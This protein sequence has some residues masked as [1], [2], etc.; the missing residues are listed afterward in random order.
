MHEGVTL[1]ARPGGD[2]GLDGLFASAAL[3]A[4]DVAAALRLA[5]EV[6]AAS[7]G[8]GRGRTVQYLET[9]ATLGAADV[10]V[11]RVVE[12]HLDALAVLAECPDD[13]DLG[14]VGV[15]DSSTWGV[16]AAEAP[17]VRLTAVQD[18]RGWTLSGTKPWCSLAGDLS[19]AL[20]TAHV[21]GPDGGGTRRLFAVALGRGGM[22]VHPEAWV[23]RGMPTVPSGPVDFDAVAAVPVGAAGWY[24]ERDGFEWGGIGV[25]ACWFGGAVGIGRRVLDAAARR[26][27][28]LSEL[29]AGRCAAALNAARAVLA[30]AAARIDGGGLD[31]AEARI[32]AQEVRSVVRGAGELVLRE[33]AHA[34][35]PAPLALDAGYAARVADLELYLLQ[36]HGDRDLARLG[37]LLVERETVGSSEVGAA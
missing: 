20:V 32:L 11:A 6:G 34:L 5:R 16:F 22:V 30:G 14:A 10:T 12:P 2:A 13:V 28:E 4:V 23:A 1:D 33:A 25:A 17:G 36:D 26:P 29:H 7:P 15:D 19:H 24:L 3:A 8:P 37:R 27:G 35:G 31:R 9:L 21:D 18:A